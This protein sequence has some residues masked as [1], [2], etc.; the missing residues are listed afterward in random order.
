[1]SYVESLNDLGNEAESI[2]ARINEDPKLGILLL[3]DP[4]R[5]FAEIGYVL[6]PQAA[7]AARKSLLGATRAQAD[8]FYALRD[9]LGDRGFVPGISRVRLR[10]RATSTGRP[11]SPTAQRPPRSPRANPLDRFDAVLELSEAVADHVAK[12]AYDE[13]LFPHRFNLQI[14][15]LVLGRPEDISFD[16]PQTDHARIVLPVALIPPGAEPI[17]GTVS[18]IVGVSMI[19]AEGE[20]QTPPDHVALTFEKIEQ[21]E[22]ANLPDAVGNL[23]V[24]ALQNALPNDVQRIPISPLIRELS[25]QMSDS[26]GL[27]PNLTDISGRVHDAPGDKLDSFSVCLMFGNQ[28]PG[29]DLGKVE[30]FAK[31]S[32]RASS[33]NKDKVWSL[34]VGEE[35]IKEQF[36]DWWNGPEGKKYRRLS[37]SKAES[38]QH[39]KSDIEDIFDENGDIR[40]G[41]VRL[42]I[43]HRKL[44]MSVDVTVEDAFLW[45]D[46]DIEL[47]ADILLRVNHENG[48]LEFAVTNLDTSVSCWD[49]FL[50]ALFMGFVAAIAGAV[51]GAIVG[52]VVGA[53]AGAA[54]ASSAATGAIIGAT[55][56]L[57]AGAIV[58]SVLAKIEQLN[59]EGKLKKA[60]TSKDQKPK[61]FEAVSIAHEWQIPDT[62]LVIGAIGEWVD[63]VEGEMLIGGR[64][65]LPPLAQFF[66][67]IS[68]QSSV[69]TRGVDQALIDAFEKA[70][71]TSKSR[72]ALTSAMQ[73]T[74]ITTICRAELSDVMEGPF[75]LEW[76]VDGHPMGEGDRLKIEIVPTI[77]LMVGGYNVH[78]ER[79][80]R[81]LM[82]NG[83]MANAFVATKTQFVDINTPEIDWGAL[84]APAGITPPDRTFFLGDFFPVDLRVTDIFGQ[85]FEAS[86]GVGGIVVHSGLGGAEKGAGLPAWLHPDIDIAGLLSGTLEPRLPPGAAPDSWFRP[87]TVRPVDAL[88][89]YRRPTLVRNLTATKW[90]VRLPG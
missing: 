30:Q 42:S 31:P 66:A 79:V 11:A 10:A 12:L 63:L 56:G 9:Q 34:G 13:H 15:E 82:S 21:L 35:V 5:V 39:G 81:L 80:A 38:F 72:A 57:L 71:R 77:E 29:G 19:N 53:A 3:S 7:R 1:M 50:I 87:G 36:A 58:T 27:N 76:T 85:V 65:D 2:A 54:V 67:E 60:I 14:G 75:R 89:P 28:R 52:G 64:A 20:A 41:D 74:S 22:I 26:L 88:A 45:F 62:D 55:G 68:T 46:V 78:I 73:L 69:Q 37:K 47:T 70:H 90:I 18:L 51:V 23:V 24:A 44:H 48:K 59:A 17:S 32:S 49:I 4:V 61:Y 43:H 33:Q 83:Q 86:R 16:V 84:L 40:I 6:S 8:H 25:E